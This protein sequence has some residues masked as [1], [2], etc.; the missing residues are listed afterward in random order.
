M[1]KHKSEN[2]KMLEA[3]DTLQPLSDYLKESN[4]AIKREAAKNAF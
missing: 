1:N 4:D 3:M 2:P